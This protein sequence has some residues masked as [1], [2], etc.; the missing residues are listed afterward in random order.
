MFFKPDFICSSL[1][2]LIF[3]PCSS[4]VNKPTYLQQ[5]LVSRFL[6]EIKVILLPMIKKS[7]IKSSIKKFSNRKGLKIPNR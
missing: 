2:R 5:L 4:N 1:F 3:L 7:S 6:I